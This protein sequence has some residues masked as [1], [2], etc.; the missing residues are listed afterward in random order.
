MVKKKAG[1]RKL[2]A[3]G[4]LAVITGAAA[5]AVPWMTGEKV[6]EV[7]DGDTFII[8]HDQSIRLSSLDAP[9]IQYCYGKEAK[10]ALSRLILNKRIHLA[11]PYT[12][13]YGRIMATVY[14]GNTNVN[15]YMVRNGFAYITGMVKSPGNIALEEARDYARQNKI[16]MYKG[17]CYQATP[18]DPK[19][20]I[21]G[22]RSL[23][24]DVNMKY[25]RPDCNYYN[26]VDVL[27]YEGDQ[28][29]CSEKEAIK[30]GF[31]KSETCK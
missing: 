9:E 21:K 4:A 1:N 22:N 2:L 7:I 10:E 5:M 20:A 23:V 14:V 26:A 24:A 11:E 6:A 31:V 12:D 25:Y 29:F 3:A 19:C 8:N 15:L 17:I 16:G 27:L 13:R 28:W 18:P 30:A